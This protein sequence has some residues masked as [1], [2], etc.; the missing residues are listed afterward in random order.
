MSI[1]LSPKIEMYQ[2][3]PGKWPVAA[4][5]LCD[6]HQ[7]E[8]RRFPEQWIYFLWRPVYRD[9]PYRDPDCIGYSIGDPF[10]QILEN[11]QNEPLFLLNDDECNW[12]ALLELTLA[13]DDLEEWIE[14]MVRKL[15]VEKKQL[16]M[17]RWQRKFGNDTPC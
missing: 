1:E 8:Y 7:N 16:V 17:A 14:I 15:L 6:A 3:A 10:D 13:V 9:I 12:P 2:W 5:K 11:V 4:H